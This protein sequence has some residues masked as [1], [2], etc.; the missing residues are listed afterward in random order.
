LKP[1]ARPLR[2]LQLLVST[3]LG[4]GTRHVH[5]LTKPLAALL[6]LTALQRAARALPSSAPWEAR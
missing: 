3:A 2:I 5:D 1:E 4:G 6:L